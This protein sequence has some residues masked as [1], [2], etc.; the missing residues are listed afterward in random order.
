MRI[1]VL[2]AHDSDNIMIANVLFELESRGHELK[3]YSQFTDKKTVRM[4]DSLA[5]QIFPQNVLTEKELDWADCVL[6][7]LRAHIFLPD[8]KI[9]CK[10]YI[11]VYN[12]FMDSHWYTPGA[13]FMFTTGYTRNPQHR[14]DC[15]SMPIGCPKNDHV[16]PSGNVDE[17]KRLLFIDSGHYPFGSTGKYQVA[18]MLLD[19][20]RSFP[21]YQLIV[22]PRFLPNDTNMVHANHEH[23][24]L[25]L[26]KL[27]QEN[28]PKNLILPNE[29]IDMQELIDQCHCS[30]VMASTA[31]ID[32]ALRGKNLIIVKGIDSEDTWDLRNGVEWKNQYELREG[33]GCVVDYKD[34]LQYLPHG[35][36]C[37]DAYLDKLV[38]YRTGASK[39]MADVM[40]Y[41][42]N[43]FLLK[44]TFPKI[45]AYKYETYRAEMYVDSKL[46][47]RVL[48]QKRM[49]N[50]GNNALNWTNNITANIDYARLHNV[51]EEDCLKYSLTKKGSIQF[52]QHLKKIFNEI[53]V[54]NSNILQDDPIN[55]SY[56][57]QALFDLGYDDAILEI[58]PE[59]VLC[60]GPYS[61]Y[62]GLIYRKRKQITAAM[63]HFCAFLSEA[64]NRPYHKY[65]HEL[66]WAISQ[67]YNYIFSVYDGK[68][69][70]AQAFADLYI[71]LH[72]QR[73]I[74]IVAYK[75]RKRAHNFLPKVAEQ[76]ADTDPER[77]LKCL[78][79][80]AKWE[81]FY[82][83]RERDN[84]LKVI[85]GSKLYRLKNRI[86]WLK[87]KLKGG[88]RCLREHG[89]GYTY[90]HG[91]QKI[92]Q[93]IAKIFSNKA[94]YRIWDVFKNKVME[95]Y[96]LYSKTIQK[97][98]DD[99]RLFLS[100]PTTGDNFILAHFY[101][102]YIEREY[103]TGK[104]IFAAFG[105]GGK[106][107][108]EIFEIEN[109]EP[110]SLTE[111]HQL[112]NLLMF[113][114]KSNFYLESLHYHI[115][116]RHT[117]I[118]A[119]LDGLHD[120]NL[121][122][123]EQ[124][125]LGVTDE[126]CVAPKFDYDEKYIIDLFSKYGLI[127]GRTVLL[128]PYA[129]STRKL[130]VSF[131]LILAKR[132]KELGWCVCTNS[133]C[134][135]EPAV[136]GTIPLSFPYNYS[137]LFLE[138][139][140]VSIGLRSGFQDV[141]NAAKCLKITLYPNGLPT[142]GKI[143]DISE[144]WGIGNMYHQADQH[145]LLYSLDN[146]DNLINE[147]VQLVVNYTNKNLSLK[148]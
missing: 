37:N 129:K 29:H 69:I 59:K 42:Y 74:K 82:N 35:F 142:F 101:K 89:W 39:R 22:K 79:L 131:W 27:T 141:I 123:Q 116:Y 64:N 84:Q 41:I 55:Q 48:H 3:I 15:A 57:V 13:D 68:N 118:L 137:L 143:K 86:D 45:A 54:D 26:R 53:L 148:E 78:Q 97:Y 21:D 99:A 81:Y 6:S 119:R 30:I 114:K 73:D 134:E 103:P 98:G 87:K 14:E 47:W 12:N 83:I 72:D 71:A 1:L 112:Y 5:A 133:T 7:G 110:Y 147:I 113:D 126:E 70:E 124:A 50:I 19:I 92:Q 95:G 140:G 33:T 43:E 63:E 10:K 67:A 85:R 23:I 146:E 88:V 115:I 104:A 106:K 111:F 60:S 75:C 36:R 18:A 105:D 8:D 40:E 34:V 25:I 11:F 132:L 56:F 91:G 32:V 76:L 62:L 58:S 24:Y 20:C 90:H 66:D 138:W 135:Q 117:G 107:I 16:S 100:A 108:A 28:L 128:E 139:A 9:F 145:D 17:S 77:A 51:I 125:F 46:D 31:F 136:K 93:Y 102:P 144:Y 38:A 120:F 2:A 94:P 109:I 130:S 44:G 52:V 49:K 127:K 122:T 4:F 96:K 65:A 121:F 80:Y 61:F